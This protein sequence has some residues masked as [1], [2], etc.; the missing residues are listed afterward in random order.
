MNGRRSSK[1]ISSLT[2]GAIWK[3][4]AF[5]SSPFR[6]PSVIHPSIRSRSSGSEARSAR[7]FSSVA[8]L[9]RAESA[10][11]GAAVFTARPTGIPRRAPSE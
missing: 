3:S 2:L 11:I 10:T 1:V 6:T 7:T 5:G 4:A 8:S 9:K